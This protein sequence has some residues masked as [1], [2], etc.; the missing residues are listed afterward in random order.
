MLGPQ[1]GWFARQALDALAADV[2]TVSARSNRMAFTLD[3][4]PLPVARAG[5]PLS[6]PV[7]FGAIQVPP[8]GAPI[9]LMADRQTAGGYPKIATVIAADLPAAGQLAP[10]DPVRFAVCTLAEALAALIASERALLRTAA[11]TATP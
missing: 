6:E 9:L 8:G 1:D 10:A 3:G 4:P 7:P 5:E 2:F 11:E